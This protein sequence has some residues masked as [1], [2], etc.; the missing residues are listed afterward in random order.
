M[1][2]ILYK[3]ITML[4]KLYNYI[5]VAS[6]ILNIEYIYIYNYIYIPKLKYALLC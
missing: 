6:D 2:Y 1:L 4:Y 3:H 5:S